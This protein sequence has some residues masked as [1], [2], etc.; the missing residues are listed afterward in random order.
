MPKPNK[1]ETQKDFIA[2][3]IPYLKKE[4]P[5]IE[6]DQAVAKCYGIWKESKKDGK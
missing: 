2:R 5:G 6:T 4:E 1:G 3:C